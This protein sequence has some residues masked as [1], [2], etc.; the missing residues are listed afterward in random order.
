MTNTNVTSPIG[1]TGATQYVDPANPGS[2]FKPVISAT[3]GTPESSSAG[4]VLSN[5][6]LLTNLTLEY[7]PPRNQ[8]ETFGLLINNLFNSLYGGSTNNGVPALNGRYQPVATGIGGPLTGLSNLP[9]LF[10]TTGFFQY[11]K[12]QFGQQPYRIIPG[13]APLTYRF[14]YQL[15]F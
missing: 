13:N 7:S 2:L 4:G 10:P 12:A 8:R 15:Q 3:R 14:Y 9:I 1:S 5:S 11:D 6:R